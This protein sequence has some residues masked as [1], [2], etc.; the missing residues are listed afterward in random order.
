MM[1]GYGDDAS[2]TF[3]GYAFVIVDVDFH[4]QSFFFFE[5]DFFNCVVT[6]SFF[7]VYTPNFKQLIFTQSKKL[8]T[9]EAQN[10]KNDNVLENK[11]AL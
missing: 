4:H 11:F 2:S 6:K 1:T 10:T 8:V 9:K 3:T 5:A 7:N